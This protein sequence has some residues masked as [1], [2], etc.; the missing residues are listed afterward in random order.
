MKNIEDRLKGRMRFLS[1]RRFEQHL[2]RKKSK[3][4][5][6]MLRQQRTEC[7]NKYDSM[8]KEVESKV[9]RSE[10]NIQDIDDELKRV[11]DMAKEATDTG[12][13]AQ[14]DIH[15]VQYDVANQ[16]KKKLSCSYFVYQACTSTY[17]PCGQL[18]QEEATIPEL[19]L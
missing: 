17:Y 19:Q 6:E 9:A 11:D 18:V 5:L 1:E 13:A 8:I 10:S 2:V 16:A 15:L 12:K 3:D 4:N 14:K 7:I